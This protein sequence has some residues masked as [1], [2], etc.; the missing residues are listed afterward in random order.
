MFETTRSLIGATLCVTLFVTRRKSIAH[1]LRSYRFPISIHTL[2]V[3]T[4]G[5]T[6]AARSAGPSTASWPITH[7]S[8]APIGK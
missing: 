6:A 7:S 3:A 8:T 5:G 4:T 2:R 1:G